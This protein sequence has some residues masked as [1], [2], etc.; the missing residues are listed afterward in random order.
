MNNLAV[1]IGEEFG[2]PIGRS[3]GIGALVGN[4]ISIT[5]AIAGIA[6]LF[7]FVGGGFAMVAG[8]GFSNPEQAQ[9]GKQAVTAAVIGF[10]IVFAAYWIVR[11]IEM[12]VGV[13]FITQPKF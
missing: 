9:K 1:N 6:L 12:L 8:A 10:V 3:A 4:A 13:D 5:L 2:S 7:L 11:L